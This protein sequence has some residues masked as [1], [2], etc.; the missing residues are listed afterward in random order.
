MV[1]G[2]AD[3]LDRLQPWMHDNGIEWDRATVSVRGGTSQE[4]GFSVRAML[5][6]SEGH[7]L[8][9]IPKS[10]VL[11]V[12]NT[13]AAEIIKT[14]QLGGGLGLILAIMYELSLDAVSKW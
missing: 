3:K 2:D 7:T 14:E 4:P 1:N 10:V 11:S 8:C 13:A 12:H 9:E 5:D 6:I